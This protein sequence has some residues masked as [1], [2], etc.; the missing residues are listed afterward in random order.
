MAQ[1]PC[2][3]RRTSWLHWLLVLPLVGDRGNQSI[4]VD[5]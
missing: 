2:G 1:T 4:D 3:D 5:R